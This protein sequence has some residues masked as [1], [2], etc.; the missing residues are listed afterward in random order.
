MKTLNPNT[1]K[2]KAFIEA[3]NVSNATELY[4]VYGKFSQK[5]ELA[6][7][8]CRQKCL[9][10]GRYDLRI[11]SANTFQFTC[12]WRIE[13]NLRVETRNNSYIIPNAF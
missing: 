7:Y 2:A 3:Y 10:D 1:K 6:M 4:H 5:K 13:N 9:N 11:L 12:G 8:I